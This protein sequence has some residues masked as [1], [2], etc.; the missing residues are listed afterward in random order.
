M[1]IRRKASEVGVMLAS[2]IMGTIVDSF[3]LL[4]SDVKCFHFSDYPDIY[5]DKISLSEPHPW[6][7]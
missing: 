4:V 2:R 1:V 5:I 3:S 7:W 6:K